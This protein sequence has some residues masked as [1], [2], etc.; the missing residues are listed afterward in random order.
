MLDS[1]DPSWKIVFSVSLKFCRNKVNTESFETKL[2][3]QIMPLY[4]N[5]CCLA[6]TR[7]M[8]YSQMQITSIYC[9]ITCP[10]RRYRQKPYTWLNVGDFFKNCRMPNKH[11][12]AQDRHLLLFADTKL[13]KTK[14][15]LQDEFHI[16]SVSILSHVSVLHHI[17]VCCIHFCRQIN[18]RTDN[19]MV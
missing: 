18:V 3:L 14:L 1:I 15:I 8:L 5:C 2:L 7:W 17:N 19:K 13:W 10:S 12:S 11:F 16:A 6:N 9:L 4:A